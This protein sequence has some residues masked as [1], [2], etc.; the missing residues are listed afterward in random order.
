MVSIYKSATETDHTN[1]I[2]TVPKNNVWIDDFKLLIKGTSIT[3]VVSQAVDESHSV[4]QTIQA[5]I[6]A[7]G[8]QV[9]T[10]FPK[11]T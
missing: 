10:P 5:N 1:T 8:L 11:R 6:T 2:V 7:A 3:I 4:W 9:I